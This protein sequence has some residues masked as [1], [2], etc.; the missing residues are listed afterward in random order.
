[1]RVAFLG[2]PAFA[3]TVL[4]ALID[5]G[6]YELCVFT[7]PDKPV[8]RRAVLT[9]PPV[10]RLA[11][12]HGL[13]VHQFDHI[14]G[15]EGRAAL[16]A[17][18]P[19]CIVTAAFGQKLSDAILAIPRVEAVNVHAS[20]LP[21]YRGASPVQSCIMQGDT[22]TGVTIMRMVNR[23]DA[24]DMFSSASTPILPDETA[25]ELSARLSALGASLLLQTLPRL[26][27]GDIQAVPQEEAD[28]TT[29]RKLTRESGHVCFS[30]H[31]ARVHDLVRGMNSWPGAYALL[32]GQ[33]LKIHR[34][35]VLLD[36]ARERL[37]GLVFTDGKGGM[38]VACG[39]G[40]VEL[41]E[42]QFS[43]GKRMNGDSFLRG[44]ASAA[45]MMLT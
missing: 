23:M 42:V 30:M 25:D 41:T 3:E 22:V 4:A 1:M 44:H 27:S 40:A 28:A 9:A 16:L 31:A 37:P 8:G 14:S 35:R 33:P 15:A 34:T 13:A 12:E 39:E 29:C 21:R 10:K 5:S 18:A 19:D 2:T 7:Q 38:C 43:G 26:A 32:D 11:M 45:G 20:L 36:S 6:Q 24:G 17:F